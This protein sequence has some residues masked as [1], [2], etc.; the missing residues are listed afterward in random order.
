MSNCR[1]MHARTPATEQRWDEKL[2]FRQ[3]SH[4]NA[5]FHSL[6]LSPIFLC[7]AAMAPVAK[8]APDRESGSATMNKAVA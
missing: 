6:F 3:L 8:F 7:Q 5:A 4:R 1:G 2:F